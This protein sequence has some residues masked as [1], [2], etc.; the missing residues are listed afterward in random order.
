MTLH[1]KSNHSVEQRTNIF[2][3]YSRKDADFVDRLEESLLKQGF[4]LM[5]G[6]TDIFAFEDW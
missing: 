4:S 6:R 2:V 3:S 5:I 1:S